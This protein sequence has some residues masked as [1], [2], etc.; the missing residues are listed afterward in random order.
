MANVAFLITDI[1]K[2]GGTRKVTTQIANALSKSGHNVFITSCRFGLESAFPVD[3]SVSLISFHGEETSNF[4]LR[5]IRTFKKILSFIKENKIDVY[6]AVDL[7]LYLYLFPLYFLYL[8]HCIGWEQYVFSYH[9]SF[10]EKLARK[11]S[12]IFSDCLVVLS[13]SDLKNYKKNIKSINCIKRIYNPL[14]T[15]SDEKTDLKNKRVISAG[16]LSYEKGYDLLLKSWS[17]IEPDFPDWTLDIFGE[18]NQKEVLEQQIENDSLKNVHLNN[19]SQNIEEEFANSSIFVLSSRLES[20]GLVIIEAQSKGLPCIVSN[21]ENAQ[22][23]LVEDNVNGFLI[24]PGDYV[25]FAEKLK[26][27][28][29][30]EELREKFSKN[31]QKN[32]SRFNINNI[33]KEWN[34]LI[35][36][37]CSK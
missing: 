32:L 17:I 19:F 28:M 7:S 22:A 3:E 27:L 1:S 12:A 14:I 2:V 25:L 26:L 33:T 30:N 18:G 37:I 9:K 8:C 29:K 6:I 34:A 16:R 13:D 23:E 15:V 24:P 21:C 36:D 10:I 20:F 35:D 5:K 31:S 11:L 4:F